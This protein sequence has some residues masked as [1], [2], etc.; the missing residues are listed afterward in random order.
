MGQL[1]IV[2]HRSVVVAVAALSDR[3]YYGEWTLPPLRFFR[4]NLAEGIANFYGRNRVDYYLTEGLPLL[5]TTALPFAVV[6]LWRAIRA[7]LNG[8]PRSLLNVAQENEGAGSEQRALSPRDSSSMLQ[9]LA[10]VVVV[11]TAV[12]TLVAHK[13]VRFLYPLV[14][15]LHVLAARPLSSFFRPRLSAP[16]SALLASLL[17]LNVLVAA[18]TTQWHQRGVV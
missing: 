6:G 12:M 10:W 13:E 17:A 4:F 8:K 18:Y 14:P 11:F 16:K 9:L 15:F 3:V 1:L 2:D 7:S 5:L